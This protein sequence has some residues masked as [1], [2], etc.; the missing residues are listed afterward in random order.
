VQFDDALVSSAVIWYRNEPPPDDHQVKFSYG[1]TLQAPSITKSISTADLEHTPKWTQFPRHEAAGNRSGYCLGD[2]FTIKRGVATGDNTFFILEESKARA[3]GLP[4]Q[5]LRPVLP[6]ARSIK[7][8]EIEADAEGVPLLGKRLFLIDCDLPPD[9]IARDHPALS[10]YLKTGE[11]S[12]ATRY[13][14]R[15]RRRWYSQEKRPPAPIVCT[16]LGRSDHAGRPFRFLLNHSQA[17][18]TN[19]YLMLYPKPLLARRLEGD[20]DTVRSVWTA[21]NQIRA[22]T[23]LS[24]GRVYGGGLHK[25]EP[26]ELATVPA[27]DLAVLIGLDSKQ[28]F[29]PFDLHTQAPR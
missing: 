14:C 16:Y 10:Q 19:V 2:L 3:L 27:D 13:L 28:E 9:E 25:L 4:R 21:L 29:A 11:H 23:L 24:N 20:L 12:V 8:D 18:A 17:T 26:R 22:D 6:G 7:T 15:S 1:G 5:F